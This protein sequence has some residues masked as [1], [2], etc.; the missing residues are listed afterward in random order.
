MPFRVSL[1]A[2]R[3]GNFYTLPRRG[4]HVQRRMTH[5]NN[6]VMKLAGPDGMIILQEQYRDRITQVIEDSHKNVWY[7]IISEIITPVPGITT[8]L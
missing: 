2:R 6:A 4:V 1:Q 7:M 5:E 3:I 8:R